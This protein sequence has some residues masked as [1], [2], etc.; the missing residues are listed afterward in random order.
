[1]FLYY[2]VQLKS[3]PKIRDNNEIEKRMAVYK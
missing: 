1:M 2:M 3:V